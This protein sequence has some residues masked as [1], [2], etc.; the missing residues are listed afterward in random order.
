MI[1]ICNNA[2]EI[3]IYLVNVNK[4]TYVNNLYMSQIGNFIPSVA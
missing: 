1:Y 4:Y 3:Y 2:T